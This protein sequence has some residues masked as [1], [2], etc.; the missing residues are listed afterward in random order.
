MM[1]ENVTGEAEGA[2]R[3]EACCPICCANAFASYR[4]RRNA[5]CVGCGAKERERLMAVV[6][7]SAPID[8]QGAPI[9]HFGPEFQLSKLLRARFG[10]L[11]H[12]ADFMPELYT[13]LGAPVEKVDLSTPLRHFRRESVGGFVHAHVL[14]HVP[15]SI[16]RIVAEMNAALVPG[17]FHAVQV[18]VH[19]GWYRE[20]MDLSMPE[21]ERTARFYQKDHVRVFGSEDF[22]SRFLALFDDLRRFDLRELV[23]GAALAR[24]GVPPGALRMPTGHTVFLFIKP[25]RDIPS[26]L[27]SE[28]VLPTGERLEF[29][30]PPELHLPRYLKGRGLQRYEPL[31]LS[32]FLAACEL[33][34][35]AILDVGAN[36]GLFALSAAAAFRRT[37]HA[38]EP[39]APAAEVLQSIV[40][41]YGFPVRVAGMALAGR[42][43]EMPFFLSTRSDMSNSLNPNYRRHAG[44]V[45]VPCTS[46]D[47]VGRRLRPGV[48][49]LDT[50]T[51]EADILRGGAEVLKRD[52][53][54]V[55]L[56]VLGG[57]SGGEARDILSAHGYQLYSL[58]DP[59]V[60]ARAGGLRGLKTE[61][62]LR[63][64]IASPA[65]LDDHYFSCLTAWMVRLAALPVPG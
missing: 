64:C 56:E 40:A 22:Q 9:Y 44:E 60:I 43:G 17:G 12:A 54:I 39:F 34:D 18:P 49:K 5:R 3:L 65:P 30:H 59:E 38:F 48:V 21:E 55:L 11:Y 16:D 26:G 52:R 62:D 41:A 28:F 7:K 61:G 50:E 47:A 24:A 53:P 15:A 13:G 29:R 10:D 46:L 27:R 51:T 14:E 19:P 45:S 32:A 63:N 42:E 25:R 37:V 8:P 36:V 6:L 23:N 4:G 33:R 58:A 1:A 57:E 35:G 2:D 31:T 20:D